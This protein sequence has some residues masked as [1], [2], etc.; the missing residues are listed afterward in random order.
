MKKRPSARGIGVD[1]ET[2]ER[3]GV[4][5]SGLGWPDT[6][7]GAREIGNY[8]RIHENE[9]RLWCREGRIP[10]QKDGKGRWTVHRLMMLEWFRAGVKLFREKQK[11]E[12]LSKEMDDGLKGWHESYKCG[13]NSEIV[14]R[15]RDLPGYCPTHG[16]DREALYTGE[17]Q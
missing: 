11:Q 6:I 14:R 13:C 17:Q 10:A 2:P 1:S 15:K 12:K 9:A 16:E 5:P 7:V 8:L 4:H 3:S